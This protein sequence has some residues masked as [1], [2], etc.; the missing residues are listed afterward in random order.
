MVALLAAV[1]SA[2]NANAAS[3]V[4][5]AIGGEGIWSETNIWSA[6]V[7]PKTGD[8]VFIRNGGIVTLN[9]IAATNIGNITIGE[10]NAS[11]GTLKIVTGGYLQLTGSVAVAKSSQ[12]NGIGILEINGGT[13]VKNGD[14]VVGSGGATGLV[15]ISS[16]T[17]SG[18]LKLGSASATFDAN[19]KFRIVGSTANISGAA[20]TAGNGSITEFIFDAAGI[21]SMIISGTTRFFDGAQIVIDGAAYAGGAQTFNLISGGTLATTTMPT[22][23][24]INFA[25][26]TTY[27]YNAGTDILSVTV[28]PE[29]ATIGMVGLGALAMLAIRRYTRK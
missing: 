16:G 28:V 17:L 20:Y 26:G 27:D 3:I 11:S 6:A 21:S 9:S 18:S 22:I 5:R 24:L 10:A 7:V 13:F 29:P 8:N 14:I 25:E 2:T 12:V 19:D 4:V 15:S 23:S 1:I